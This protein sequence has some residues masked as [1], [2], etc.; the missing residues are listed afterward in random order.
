MASAAGTASSTPMVAAAKARRTDSQNA[1]TMSPFSTIARNQRSDAPSKGIEMK[2]LSVKATSIT[3]TSGA[4]MKVRKQALKVSP[5][6]P[7]SFMF[8]L[9]SIENVP[10][11][12][13]REAAA[14]HHDR[15]V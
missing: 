11:A 9:R 14:A 3:T 4:R 1:E 5:S 7:F 15:D 10:E 2:P 13:F 12:A 8:V 6:Q